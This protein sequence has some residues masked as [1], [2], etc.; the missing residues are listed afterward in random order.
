M[1]R[2]LWEILVPTVRPDGKSYFRTR[3]HKAYDKRLTEISG[4]LSVLPP[5]KGSWVGSSG[6]LLQERM[7][8]VRVLAT[9]E[10]IE[11]IVDFTLK[12]Y[13]QEAVL[14]YKIS[15]EVILRNK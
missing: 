4:G 5:L 1:E 11:K 12:Y 14:A 7:I 15:D 6:I 2:S 10:E 8:P 9:R 13:Q 3:F